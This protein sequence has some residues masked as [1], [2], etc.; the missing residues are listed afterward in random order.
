MSDRSITIFSRPSGCRRHCATL[1]LWRVRCRAFAQTPK[2]RNVTFPSDPI[3]IR[4]ASIFARRTSSLQRRSPRAGR[5]AETVKRLHQAGPEP[6][7]DALSFWFPAPAATDEQGKQRSRRRGVTFLAAAA[8]SG[9]VLRLCSPEPPSTGAGATVLDDDGGRPDVRKRLPSAL[10]SPMDS[11]LSNP[12]LRGEIIENFPEALFATLAKDTEEYS[13]SAIAKMSS[14]NNGF[15]AFRHQAHNRAKFDFFRL[16]QRQVKSLS[17]SC[18]LGQGRTTASLSW[19]RSTWEPCSCRSKAR[20]S[21]DPGK[22]QGLQQVV[23]GRD[24]FF[25]SVRT[26]NSAPV[27]RAGCPLPLTAIPFRTISHRRRLL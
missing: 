10:V 15:V 12:I 3:S 5:F 1:F 22:G 19:M 18:A 17:G 13:V 7:E 8:S 9:H 23:G 16:G 24:L 20:T 6:R 25:R 2:R 27:R 26:F 21:S 14:F 4:F 11:R